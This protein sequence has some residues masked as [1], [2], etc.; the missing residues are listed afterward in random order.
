[1]TSLLFPVIL[2]LILTFIEYYPLSFE[3]KCYF[4]NSVIQQHRG[5]CCT[6]WDCVLCEEI[7]F[8]LR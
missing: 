5:V 3:I 2:Q 4:T 1:M 6:D 7:Q 8:L